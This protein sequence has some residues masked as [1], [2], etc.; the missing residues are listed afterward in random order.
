MEDDENRLY[1]VIL[2][3]DSSVGKTSLLM[4]LCKDEFKTNMTAT[5]GMFEL[6]TFDLASSHC[7]TKKIGRKEGI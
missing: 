1:K 2:V 6:R 4:R 3:G 7:I 5:L